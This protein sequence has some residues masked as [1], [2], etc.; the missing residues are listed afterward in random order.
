MYLLFSVKDERFQ[1]QDN[2]SLL[3]NGD[4]LGIRE[5]T[6]HTTCWASWKNPLIILIVSTISL[7]VIQSRLLATYKGWISRWVKVDK[8]DTG[9][10]VFWLMHLK[11]TTC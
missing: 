1:P 11:N 3:A 8:N 9:R 10:L 5:I 2:R 4:P 6:E 7:T